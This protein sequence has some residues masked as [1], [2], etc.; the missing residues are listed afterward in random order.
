MI[1]LILRKQIRGS[2]SKNVK[3]KLLYIE[4]LNILGQNFMEYLKWLK[5]VYADIE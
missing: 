3:K 1:P 5:T 2:I 4:I